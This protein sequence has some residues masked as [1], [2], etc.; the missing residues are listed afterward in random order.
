MQL[1]SITH[2]VDNQTPATLYAAE[3][4]LLGGQ[5]PAFDVPGADARERLTHVLVAQVWLRHMQAHGT[6]LPAA[7]RA[8]ARR[9]RTCLSWT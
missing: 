6:G 9:V 3:I 8:F 5:Q 4:A 2:L 1:S 7:R